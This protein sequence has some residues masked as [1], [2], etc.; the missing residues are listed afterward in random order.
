M[1]IFK[2]LNR[3]VTEN[4]ILFSVCPER[5]YQASVAEIYSTFTATNVSSTRFY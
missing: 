1:N 2:I 5:G 4:A 3:F